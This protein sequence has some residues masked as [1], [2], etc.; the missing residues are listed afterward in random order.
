MKAQSLF[1]NT[2]ILKE[3]SNQSSLT[4]LHRS[5][6]LSDKMMRCQSEFGNIAL[7][8]SDDNA[9]GLANPVLLDAAAL[10][11]VAGTLSADADITFTENNR[12]VEWKSGMA[13]GTMKIVYSD[14]AIDP[15]NHANYPWEPGKDFAHGLMLASS[16]CQ[17]AATAVGL[18]GI[19]I[20]PENDDLVMMSSNSISLAC[21]RIQKGTYPAGTVTIR[22]PVPRILATFI[23]NCP[24]CKLDITN[25]GIFMKGDWLIAHLPLAI[26]L[27]HDLKPYITGY[28]SKLHQA[29]INGDA[30]RKFITRA[31]TMMDKNT[32][33]TIAIKVEKGNLVLQHTSVGA[34]TEEYFLASD[35]DPNLKFDSVKMQ[36]DLIATCLPYV[37]T[38]V[39]DYLG[40]PIGD[41]KNPAIV[42][43]GKKA[44]DF[45]YVLGGG[46]QD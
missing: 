42:F 34:S 22:P 10:T 16:A 26:K 19:V 15:L 44:V 3:I 18:Y 24:N 2:R 9:T 6:E 5:I 28:N 7:T 38:A 14:S 39:F 4:A 27:E 35:L 25:E 30:V 31:R 17:A 41:P 11:G 46:T 21:S 13:S 37:D 40:E 36:A 43:Y 1:F 8:L 29:A 20:E 23:D 12:Q 32:M 33:F 45:T